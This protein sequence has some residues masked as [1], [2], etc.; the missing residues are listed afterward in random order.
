MN[1]MMS[2][3]AGLSML[4]SPKSALPISS[5]GVGLP[6]WFFFFPEG[7]RNDVDPGEQQE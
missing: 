7:G 6:C 1:L 4:S 3:H 2:T 5:D